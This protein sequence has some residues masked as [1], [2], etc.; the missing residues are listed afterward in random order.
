MANYFIA[1]AYNLVFLA[2]EFP[3][4]MHWIGYLPVGRNSAKLIFS[5][6]DHRL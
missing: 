4:E 1:G 3:M 5:E 6:R 2:M